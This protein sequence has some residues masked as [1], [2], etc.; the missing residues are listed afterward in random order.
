MATFRFSHMALFTRVEHLYTI[1]VFAPSLIYHLWRRDR[2]RMYSEENDDTWW[3]R[4]LIILHDNVRSHSAA[5]T[6][7]L[8]CWQWEIL[9]HP[10][11]SPDMSPCDYDLVAKVKESQRGM[12]YNTR[13]KLIRAVGGSI[14]DIN[15]DGRAIG[16]RRLTNIW[17][18]VINKRGDYIEGT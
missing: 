6:D 12:R 11:Y 17:Q 5:V 14:W 4:T 7:L 18:N 8:S 15:K 13:D 2:N 10:P 3:Y 9:E 16:V 1:N